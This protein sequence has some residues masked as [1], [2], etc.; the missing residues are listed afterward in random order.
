MHILFLLS[1]IG[2]SYTFFDFNHRYFWKTKPQIV[3]CDDA[4]IDIELVKVAINF[5]KHNDFLMNDQ[6]IVKSCEKTH[7]KGEIRITNQ[8]DLDTEKYYAYTSRDI[9]FDTNEISSATILTSD[10]ESQ[11][12]KLL[13]HEMG[14]ALGINHSNHDRSHIMHKH[15]V[16]EETRLY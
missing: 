12:L 11:N 1:S 8:R 2:H 16:D 10:N 5:W 13:I 9:N 15:V 4:K 6:L 3:L 14:H 7:K